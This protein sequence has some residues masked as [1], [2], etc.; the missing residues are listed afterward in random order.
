MRVLLTV[1]L[2]ST[3]TLAE[4][5]P[6]TPEKIKAAAES[7]DR[8]AQY[9]LGNMYGSGQGVS[10]DYVEAAKWYRKAAEQGVAKAQLGLGVMYDIFAT[11]QYDRRY[12]ERFAYRS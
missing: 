10:K 8:N 4:D 11:G 5:K 12:G 3:V 2:L 1:L 6:A 9:Q 7:G